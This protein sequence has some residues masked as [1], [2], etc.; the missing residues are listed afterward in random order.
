MTELLLPPF[1]RWLLYSTLLLVTGVLG[2]RGFVAGR[3]RFALGGGDPRPAAELPAVARLERRMA[4]IG[5]AAALLLLVA[6]GLRLLVQLLAFRDPFVPVSED[7]AFLVGDPLW[8][9][10]WI[11]QGLAAVGLAAAFAWL[12]ATAGKRAPPEPGLT[13]EGIPRTGPR[14]VELPGAWRGAAACV[15]L[16]LLTLG[17]SSHA[18]SVPWNRPLAVG[19][20]IAHATAAGLWIGVLALVLLGTPRG[21]GAGADGDE[22]PPGTLLAAQLRAFSPL[23]MGSVGVLLFMGVLLSGYHLP[24]I[25]ALWESRY[26]RTLLVKVALSL[27]VLALG[28]VNWRKGLPQVDTPA[29]RGR[30]R[31][32]ASLEVGLA[33]AVLLVTAILVATPLPPGAHDP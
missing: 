1:Q 16:L 19:V 29:G 8:G 21:A 6:W 3:V 31:R 12:R 2:W 23:A 30:L 18:M 14:P 25:P 20:D 4:A 5:L 17:L 15:A 33:L 10:V 27:G 26:G 28:F 22:A 11:V 7:L 9:R 32:A 13:P 24:S